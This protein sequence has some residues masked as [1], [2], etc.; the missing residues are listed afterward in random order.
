MAVVGTASIIVRAIT[1][2]AGDDIARFFQGSG[3]ISNKAGKSF[4]DEFLRGFNKSVDVNVFSRVARGLNTMAPG[5]QAARE[6]FQALSKAGYTLGPAITVIIGAISALIGSLV[7]LVGAAGGAAATLV[8]LG[9]VFAGFG[10]AMLSAKIALGGVMEAL[11]KMGQAGASAIRSTRAVEQAQQSLA[12]VLERN[13][14]SIINANNR[15]TDAQ[16][17]LNDALEAGR[18]ELQQLAFQA[19]RTALAE[20]GAALDLERARE[21]LARV[22]DLPPNSRLRREAELAFAQAELQYREA[23]DANADIAAEQERY[24][25]SG[26]EGTQ[27]VINARRQLAEAEADLARTVRDGLRAQIQA[28]QAL[29]EAR[30]SATA[31]GSNPYEGLTKSQKEFVKEVYK[32]KPLFDDVQEQVAAAFLPLLGGAIKTFATKVLPSI[33]DGLAVIAGALGDAAVRFADFLASSEGMELINKFF[34]NS[35]KLIPPMADAFGLLMQIFIRL[36]NA[37]APIA[38]EFVGFVKESF[39]SFNEYLKDID[40][41]GTLNQFFTDASETAKAF[42]DLIGEVFEAIGNIIGVNIGADSPGTQFVVWMA[43]GLEKMNELNGTAEGQNKLSDY[44]AAVNDNTQKVLSSLGSLFGVFTDLGAN[45]A[46]GETFAIFQEGEPF[47]KSI[48]DKV[49]EGAPS[50]ATM[51]NEFLR[52]MDG[53]T[54]TESIIAFN[55]TLGAIFGTIADIVESELFQKVFNFVS[56]IL[57]SILAITTLVSILTFFGNVV[58]AGLATTMSLVGTA[59]GTIFASPIMLGIALLV[60]AFVTL[61]NTSDQ[62]RAFVDGVFAY[63]MTSFGNI[64]ETLQGIL[65]PFIEAVIRLWQD[66]IL[67]LVESLS[68][69]LLPILAG[70]AIAIGYV[71]TIV[72]A[73]FVPVFTVLIDIVAEVIKFITNFVDFL[74]GVVGGVIAIFSGDLNRGFKLIF[75]SLAMFLVGIIDMLVNAI[76]STINGVIDI[77]NGLIRTFTKSEFANFLRD[78]TGGTINIT[79]GFVIPKIPKLNL[80]G[81]VKS[82]IGLATGGTV[83]PQSGGVLATIAEAGKPERVEPLDSSGLSRRDRAMIEMLAGDKGQ[84]SPINITVNPSPGMDE[85]ALAGAVSQEITKLMRKGSIY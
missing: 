68:Y 64:F 16:L 21:E 77:I 39:D 57:A 82:G 27:Q 74:R 75:G 73:V 5:A 4:G 11:G 70:L 20:R 59:L 6:Q 81:A 34:E 69:F 40:G 85:R 48:V 7:S 17:N 22:Q 28:E 72:A 10:L 79:G 33:G 15:I 66:A 19:E 38:E 37:A 12:L 71:A 26:V 43:E 30:E 31:A 24:V 84:G 32:L 35:A 76:T 55:D 23:L 49:V 47:L 29:Q 78:I 80:A 83:F 54:D 56:P 45:P 25:E 13:Q 58:L 2:G 63:T 1:T 65:A 8:V 50:F 60:A 42:G 18:E 46:I 3:K 67:P 41:D 14:E 51:V 62:F 52:L 61:Y 36:I 53:L 9:N 44:F